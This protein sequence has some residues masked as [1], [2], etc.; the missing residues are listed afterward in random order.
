MKIMYRETR[1]SVNG[2][3]FKAEEQQF[4]TDHE[5]EILIWGKQSETKKHVAVYLNHSDI[6]NIIETLTLKSLFHVFNIWLKLFWIY[7]KTLVRISWRNKKVFAG[8]ALSSIRNCVVEKIP[9]KYRCKKDN[10]III[11]NR[12]AKF[13]YEINKRF[14]NVVLDYQKRI[15]QPI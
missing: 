9:R 15:S 1:H 13:S 8:K 11:V 14:Y 10:E 6:Y 3:D 4:K 7:V 5:N 12:E 2:L